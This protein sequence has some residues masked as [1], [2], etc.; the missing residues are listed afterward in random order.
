MNLASMVYNLIKNFFSH[1]FSRKTK[2]G[3]IEVEEVK[4]IEVEAAPEPMPANVE[5]KK[6]VQ[7]ELPLST[8]GDHG[9]GYEDQHEDE[10]QEAHE[11]EAEGPPMMPAGSPESWTDDEAS[12]VRS[13]I[14]WGKDST[15]PLGPLAKAI[16]EFVPRVKHQNGHQEAVLQDESKNGTATTKNEHP[17]P[18]PLPIVPKEP[19]APTQPTQLEAQLRAQN[20]RLAQELER[21]F[22]RT[23]KFYNQVRPAMMDLWRYAQDRKESVSKEV[24]YDK[25]CQLTPNVA[26][27]LRHSANVAQARHNTLSRNQAEAEKRDRVQKAK[28]AGGSLRGSSAT[29]APDAAKTTREILEQQFDRHGIR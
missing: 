15:I 14:Q 2:K 28:A 6:E 1:L 4:T 26:A 10:D 18:P 19:Q 12:Q 5:V 16:S 21:E 20:E 9:H 3:I 17:S 22:S 7:Q 27:S 13:V 29:P 8:D 23:H 24:L 11:A 25:A